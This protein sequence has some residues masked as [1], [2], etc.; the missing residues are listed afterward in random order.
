[1]RPRT[2]IGGLA[3]A[4]CVA[5][6]V[7]AQAPHAEAV[8]TAQEVQV[9]SG[10]S[11]KYYPTSKLRAGDRVRVVEEKEGGWLAI[12]PPLGSFS[13]IKASTIDRHGKV[14]IVSGPSDV[15]V[16]SALV[17]DEPTVQQTRLQQGAQV[18]IF[19]DRPAQKGADQWYPIQPPPQEVRYIPASAVIR[20]ATP[21][22][23]VSAPAGAPAAATS[24]LD[25]LLAQ[26]QAAE[27]A[28]NYAEADRLFRQLYATTRDP[29]VQQ[30]CVTHL[31]AI[32]PRLRASAAAYTPPAPAYQP[33]APAY[34]APAPPAYAPPVTAPAPA[35]GYAYGQPC[36]PAPQPQQAVSQYASQPAQPASFSRAPAMPQP[37]ANSA[38]AIWSNPGYLRHS[39][40]SVAARQ[41]YA[42]ESS[43]GFLRLYVT[44]APGVNLEPYVGKNVALYGPTVYSSELKTN[45]MQVQQVN[46]V[47]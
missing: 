20:A 24:S 11:A 9:L 42:L 2:W 4:V 47:Q 27:N 40:L 39:S 34:Q 12:E 17:P 21:V 16:G 31:D 30:A 22:Q 10:P 46:P 13:W 23:T 3:A 37:Q 19:E 43:E 32:A 1:M 6:V 25:P 41:T 14:A 38:P 29:Q 26:A 8:V 45:Y 36:P 44:A 7:R 5:S 18:V 35:P 33:P 15:L 28:G